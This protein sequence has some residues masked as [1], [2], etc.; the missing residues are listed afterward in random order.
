MFKGCN[1]A[2]PGTGDFLLNVNGSATS[3]IDRLDIEGCKFNG[4]AIGGC[5]R[6]NLFDSMAIDTCLFEGSTVAEAD[7]YIETA[8]GLIFIDD[9]NV[10]SPNPFAGAA[11]VNNYVR[12]KTAVNTLSY[13]NGATSGRSIRTAFRAP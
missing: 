8:S 9:T 1:F 2:N 4:N 3:N 11:P 7:F 5:I 13:R 10:F 6:A 12:G